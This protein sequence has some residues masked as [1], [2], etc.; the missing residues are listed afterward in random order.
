M[1]T[2]ELVRLLARGAEE[3]D[4]GALG[5]RAFLALAFAALLA[6]AFTAT[7]LGLHPHWA[8]QA[9]ATALW[10]REAYCASLSVAGLLG[11]YRL[12]HP[13]RRLG[14]L[15]WALALPIVLM[16][17][18]ALVALAQAPGPQRL[19]LV[20]GST[21]AVCPWLIALLSAPIFI[22]LLWVAR[23]LA[24]TRLAP[25]AALAGFA[26]GACGSL[27]YTLHCPELA[28]PFL[29]VWYLLGMSI[30]TAVGYC[31]GARLLRW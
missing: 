11:A 9:P 25:A 24:P 26:A 31:A 23:R 18:L 7:I 17:A 19:A 15:R 1:R 20:M 28:A 13:G 22:A 4:H 5:W 6:L 14:N 16:V 10:T 29:A 3:P 30:P 2:E 8:Q 21:A 27:I 12:A